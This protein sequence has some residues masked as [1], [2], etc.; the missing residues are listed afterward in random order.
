VLPGKRQS[1]AQFSN[2][3][4]AEIWVP[5]I[6]VEAY[7]STFFS[8]KTMS[9]HGRVFAVTERNVRAVPVTQ[10]E[11]IDNP[12]TTSSCQLPIQLVL[13][14]AKTPGELVKDSRPA[15]HAA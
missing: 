8:K 10:V 4:L 1:F 9:V 3:Y 15:A 5:Q 2:K 12:N 6:A 11:V 14:C 7:H 13:P